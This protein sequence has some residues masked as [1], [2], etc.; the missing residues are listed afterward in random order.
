M[1]YPPFRSA[2]AEMK[3]VEFSGISLY[4]SDSQ[5]LSKIQ[6]KFKLI[7]T[8]LHELALHPQK[9]RIDLKSLSVSFNYLSQLSNPKMLEFSN[10]I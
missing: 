7:M 10:K 1:T 3:R 6:K 5:I 9:N 2:R 8:F 4:F